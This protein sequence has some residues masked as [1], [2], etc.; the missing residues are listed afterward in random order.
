MV[1]IVGCTASAHLWSIGDSVWLLWSH[2]IEHVEGWTYQLMSRQL[3]SFTLWLIS[4]LAH[5]TTYSHIACSICVEHVEEGI[6]CTG[7]LHASELL[8]YFVGVVY[9][10]Y[11]VAERPGTKTIKSW[12]LS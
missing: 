11:I 8:R 4:C 6:T 3:L 10:Q 2:D 5:L 9:V 12:E 7:S 1:I